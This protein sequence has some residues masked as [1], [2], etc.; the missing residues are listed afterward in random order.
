M[1]KQAARSWKTSAVGILT[2][3]SAWLQCAI[4][5]LDGVA[6]TEPQYGLAVTLTI[7]AIGLLAAKDGDK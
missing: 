2:A 7:A 6:E 3:V 5:V 1:V 4:A